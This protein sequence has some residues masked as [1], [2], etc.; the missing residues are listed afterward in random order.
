MAS[1]MVG[2]YLYILLLHKCNLSPNHLVH[3]CELLEF[4]LLILLFFFSFFLICPF[5]HTKFCM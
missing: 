5:V 2:P 4:V 3:A 1:A